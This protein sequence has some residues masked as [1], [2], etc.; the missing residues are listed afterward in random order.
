MPRRPQLKQSEVCFPS[1]V[2]LWTKLIKYMKSVTVS[3]IPNYLF[4]APSKLAECLYLHMA[5]YY[6]ASNLPLYDISLCYLLQ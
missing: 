1:S 3:L 2:F 5:F 6:W 4:Q